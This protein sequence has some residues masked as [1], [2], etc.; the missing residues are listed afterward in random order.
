MEEEDK[1]SG[2]LLPETVGATIVKNANFVADQ[3]ANC[4]V[5]GTTCDACRKKGILK[6]PVEEGTNQWRGRGRVGLVL[7]A[8]EHCRSAHSAESSSMHEEQFGWIN[9]QQAG[10]L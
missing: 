3:I 7:D 10:G 4:P 6:G 2:Q 9:Q 8:N 5:K 1:H